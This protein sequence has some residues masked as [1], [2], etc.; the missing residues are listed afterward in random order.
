MATSETTR[1]AVDQGALAPKREFYGWKLIGALWCIFFL[2]MGFPLYG[3]A[4]INSYMM[5]EIHMPR[6]VYGLGFSLLNFFVSVPSMLIAAAI[7]RWGARGTFLIGSGLIFCGAMWMAF[8]ATQPWQYLVGF[9]VLIGAGIG[10]ATFLPISTVV[11]RWFKHYRGRCMAFVLTA[12]E[13]AGLLAAPL[14][15]KLI[16]VMSGR[17][18]TGWEVVAC[19]AICSGLIAYFF[20]KEHPADLGQQVDNGRSVG[21][22]D[23]RK[24]RGLHTTEEWTTGEVYRSV[25]FW[26]IVLGAIACE[27]PF[28]FFTAHWLVYLRGLGFS[29]ANAALAQGMFSIGG[30]GGL[31]VGGILLDFIAARYTYILGLACYLLG[32]YL[33]MRASH[34]SLFIIFTAAILYGAA[35]NWTFACANTVAGNFYGAEIFPKVNGTLWVITALVCS[36]AAVIAGILFDAYK[37]YAPAFELNIVICVIGMLALLFARMPKRKIVQAAES[38]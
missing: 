14:M 21:K 27:Y 34:E 28:F 19:M 30:V 13:F 11:N 22:D 31:I 4:V 1:A 37:S 10:F 26:M 16:T 23:A 7:I 12:S 29:P 5:H 6:S 35:F 9:G 18:R 24:D 25:S 32:T 33:A 15:N 8:L 36:P 17:W 3:G 2:N 20:V 38:H